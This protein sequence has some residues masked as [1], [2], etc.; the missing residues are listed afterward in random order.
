M[1]YIAFYKL[2]N[3]NI[4]DYYKQGIFPELKSLGVFGVIIRGH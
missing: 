1:R 3:S 2:S 4:E